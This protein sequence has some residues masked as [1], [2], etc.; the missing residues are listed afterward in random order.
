MKA[1]KIKMQQGC[2]YSENLTEID[3]IYLTGCTNEGY[4]EKEVLHNYLKEHPNTIQVDIYP[5]PNLQPV[6]SSN[7]EKYVRSEKD[8]TGRD[9][10]L[11]LPRE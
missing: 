2:R 3:K 6:V 11:C 1:I 9:N 4:F 10:L 8:Y 5:Y 7:C